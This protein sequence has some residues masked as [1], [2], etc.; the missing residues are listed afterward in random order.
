M[1]P[2]AEEN[3][4][5]PR[6]LVVD[7]ELT[8]LAPIVRALELSGYR[9]DG[10]ASGKEA[11][12]ML[13]KIFEPFYTTDDEGTGLGLSVCH[14]LVTSHGGRIAVESAVG[15]GSTFTVWLPVPAELSQI[16]PSD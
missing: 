16:K 12:A 11:L 14:N 8:I 13:D 3:T 7:D 5:A 15:R 6:I 10:V 1:T 9:P 4:E 2:S